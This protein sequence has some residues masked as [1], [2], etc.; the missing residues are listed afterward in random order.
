MKALLTMF[1]FVWPYFKKL[2]AMFFV[3]L[4]SAA[5]FML[6]SMTAQTYVIGQFLDG[7]TGGS[8]TYDK[9]FLYSGAFLAVGI[10]N[11]LLS[12]ATKLLAQRVGVRGYTDLAQQIYRRLQK[13]S[14]RHLAGKNVAELVNKIYNDSGNLVLYF[15]NL[16]LLGPGFALTFVVTMGYI[17]YLDVWCG[18]IAFAIVPMMILMNK[19]M[20]K[21]LTEVSANKAKARD[22]YVSSLDEQL[23]PVRSIRLNSLF[24]IMSKRYTRQAKNLETSFINNEKVYFPYTMLRSNLQAIITMTLM[25][26]AGFAIL[27]GRMTI[28][29]FVIIQSFVSV[30]SS[31]LSYLMS[32]NE[33]AHQQMA[34]YTRLKELTE[35][36]EEG[37]GGELP[38]PLERITVDGLDF[39]YQEDAPVLENLSQRFERGKIYCLVGRNGSGKST[40]ADV[41]LGLY[42][43]D[44]DGAVKYNG[45]P[46]QNIDLYRMRAE[47]IGV[48][49]QEPIMLNGSIGF[50]ITYQEE[51][52]EDLETI[53]ELLKLLDFKKGDLDWH[54]PE[55]V[56]QLN[57]G[58]L[59]GGQKQKV[60]VVK[61]LYKN[62][63]LLLLD[64]PTSA[65]DMESRKRLAGYLKDHAQ[66]RIT[67]LVSHDQELIGIADQV[68]RMDKEPVAAE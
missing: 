42:V 11:V 16:G 54:D 46:L 23:R 44:G 7:L 39:S 58:E 19:L 31:C 56:L 1:R 57:A 4:I 36:P 13:A 43:S 10:S 14:P 66:G 59:S 29:Q 65:L 6:V 30:V 41:L 17:F 3:Y 26:Y 48:S 12:Y 53:Q 34:L 61:A 55:A 2:K 32:I 35:I 67:I 62:P 27:G 52:N 37:N 64:E 28:G 63:E 5:L 51:R 20:G 50:N 25:I 33:D 22:R 9:I 60:S 49:E 24:E 40:L 15:V 21:K 45:I 8:I 38:S 47:R 68:V 18:L